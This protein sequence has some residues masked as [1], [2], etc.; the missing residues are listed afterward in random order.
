[1]NYVAQALEPENKQCDTHLFCYI[2]SI[3]S[4][5]LFLPMY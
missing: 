2:G 3:I 1:M 5:N 4:M